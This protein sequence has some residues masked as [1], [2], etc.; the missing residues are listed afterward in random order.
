MCSTFFIFDL[1]IAKKTA[2]E[3]DSHVDVDS[4]EV[5]NNLFLSL[6]TRPYNTINQC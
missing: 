6:H 5:Q 2:V 1:I 4:R 3:H